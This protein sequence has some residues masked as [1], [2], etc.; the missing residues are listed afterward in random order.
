MFTKAFDARIGPLEFT[1]DYPGG[2]ATNLF[3]PTRSHQ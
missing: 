2:Y 3:S 1:R